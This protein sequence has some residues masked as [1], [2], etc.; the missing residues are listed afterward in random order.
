MDSNHLVRLSGLSPRQRPSTL[1]RLWQDSNPHDVLLRRQLAY[2][3]A[4]R[5]LR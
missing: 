1:L 2:P 4:H 5:G 3:L